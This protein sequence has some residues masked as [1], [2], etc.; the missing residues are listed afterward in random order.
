MPAFVYILRCADGR[1][2]VGS[3]RGDTPDRRI[4]E[5]V[6]GEFPGF[7]RARR[8]VTVVHVEEFQ[9]IT[10]AVAAERRIKG[11]SRSKK[12][13]LIAGDW[14]LLQHLAKRP[15]ARRKIGAKLHRDTP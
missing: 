4:G 5:H 9:R 3:T 14:D 8:P 15:A 12:E 7:T 13:A 6:G 1:Y 10:D 11:W 2:Y